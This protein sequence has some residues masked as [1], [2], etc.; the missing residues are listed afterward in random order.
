MSGRAGSVRRAGRGAPSRRAA[1]AFL[2]VGVPASA[3]GG[4]GPRAHVVEIQGFAYRPDSLVVAVGDTVVWVNRDAVPHT[5]TAEGG[6]WDSGSIVAGG[7]WRMVAGVGGRHGYFCVFHPTM[8]G[9]LVV[10]AGGDR[11]R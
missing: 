1:L 7:S 4:G 11:G 2:V 6:A 8:R 10:A 5:A 9:V 3:C